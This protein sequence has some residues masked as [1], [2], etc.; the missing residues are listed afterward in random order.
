MKT[1]HTFKVGREGGPELEIVTSAGGCHK[2]SFKG[3]EVK[4]EQELRDLCS[5]LTMIAL[6]KVELLPVE[7]EGA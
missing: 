5:Y 2:A 4:G 3:E 7:E 1:K 6:G